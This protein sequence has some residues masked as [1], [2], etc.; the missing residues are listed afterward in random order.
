[1]H[2]F[3]L[4]CLNLLLVPG[5]LDPLPGLLDTVIQRV[6]DE[7]IEEDN[8]LDDSDSHGGHQARV[9]HDLAVI[10]GIRITAAHI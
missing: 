2:L 5:C 9:L 10:G 8:G 1:M 7:V 6:S 4:K 3:R